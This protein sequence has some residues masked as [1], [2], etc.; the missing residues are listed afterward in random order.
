MKK[1][2]FSKNSWP[3][4]EYLHRKFPSIEIFL[5]GGAIRDA[6][7]NRKA[8]DEDFVIRKVEI[9]I[10]TKALKTIGS[11]DLVGKRFGV[12]KFRPKDTKIQY[13]IAL[14]RREFSRSFTGAYRDFEIHSDPN[15][16][17]EDDLARR[18]FTI[19][20]MAWDITNKKLVD[21][22]L[23]QKD[24]KDKTIRSVGSAVMRF[25]EDYSRMLRAVRFACQLNFSLTTKTEAAI[26][27]LGIHLQD[28]IDNEWVV[29]REVISQEFIKA[30]DANPIKCL[31]LLDDLNL[32]KIILP[33]LK[34]LQKCEQTPPYHNEGNVF[35]HTIRALE[36]TQTKEYK[37]Y[38]PEE[39]P[40]LSKLGI[41]LHDLG[42]IKATQK[43]KSGRI[44]FKG[45]SDKGAE[46]VG[47]LCN[48]MRLGSSEYAPFK[49][50][51]LVWLV[52]HHLFSINDM[53]KPGPLTE[54]ERLFFSKTY[55]SQ[56]LL[57]LMLAD[58]MGTD[59][60]KEI[61]SIEPFK[62]LWARLTKMAP[63]GKLPHPLLRGSDVIELR[64]IKPGP[65]V[66]EY[67]EAIREEQLR[68]K[69]TTKKQAIQFLKVL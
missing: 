11:V 7:L 55:P 63:K 69:I 53:N 45:H 18:D 19:N 46:A 43:D 47:E 1:L 50:E 48:R 20:A 31:N 57:Q 56:N 10:L 8:K 54:L 66:K 17:I 9:E 39:L 2:L 24:L 67:L 42:K 3:F 22:F 64:G 21:P 65:K 58:L 33:E 61:D 25:Q 37:K 49:C 16:P 59:T 68:K 4:V 62:K 6:L 44:H 14:P 35:N 29:A 13:D 27:K 26:K 36:M 52:K 30:L 60:N 12:L 51:H 38:F 23:G 32:L 5:V 40:P 15:L 34:D 41:V 28:R